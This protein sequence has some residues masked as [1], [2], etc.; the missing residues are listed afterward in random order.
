MVYGGLFVGV[1]LLIEGAYRMLVDLRFEPQ[2][3]V[4]RRLRMLA[5]GANPEEV[6][7]LLRRRDQRHETLERFPPLRVL[8][9]LLRHSGA[10]ISLPRLLILMALAT[11]ATYFALRFVTVPMLTA[12]GLAL[13]SG[14]LLPVGYL[15]LRRRRRLAQFGHQL[16]DALDLIVRS[17]RAGHPLSAALAVVAEEMPDPIG[18][19]FGI[20]VDEATYGLALPDAIENLAFRAGHPDLHYFLVAIRIQYGTGGNLAE[21]LAGL[22]RVIRERFNMQKKIQA[23]S[24]EGRLSATILSAMPLVVAGLIMMIHPDF[25]LSVMNDTMFPIFLYVT[26]TLIVVNLVV[27]RQLVNFRF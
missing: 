16:P 8:N 6:L 2:R 4:N 23:V 7:G 15:I 9:M 27:M 12:L 17:L 19:E 14:V 24:A 18:S 10:T 21:V 5:T 22:A 26:L 20:T 3:A 13:T 1:L 11:G 25:Y